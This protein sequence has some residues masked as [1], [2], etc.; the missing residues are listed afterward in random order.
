MK[1]SIVLLPVLLFL[2]ISCHENSV[3]NHAESTVREKVNTATP[4]KNRA[5]EEQKTSAEE[6][7]IKS[8]QDAKI[9]EADKNS[10]EVKKEKKQVP[11]ETAEAQMVLKPV[12]LKDLNLSLA[13]PEAMHM[14][15]QPIKAY[16]RN[17]NLLNTEI[18]FIDEETGDELVIKQY[19]ARHAGA[20]YD[21]YVQ[22]FRKKEG[23]FS[24]KAE[25]LHI[26]GM[27]I[28]KGVSERKTDGKGHILNPPAK[29]YFAVWKKGDELYE[30]YFRD[31]KGDGPGDEIIEKVLS[32]LKYK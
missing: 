25:K 12:Y 20:I 31:A 21:F 23:N 18:R 11:A 5:S 1:K 10:A 6:E 7:V 3:S 22:Q 15:G 19:P 16:D 29:V 14:N 4:S 24:L 32:Q 8:S 26:N 13:I 2:F 9:E 17:K 30:L 27:E 28:M